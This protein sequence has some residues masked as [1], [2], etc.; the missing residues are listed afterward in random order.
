MTGRR[1]H[2]LVVVDRP[3]P[4]LFPEPFVRLVDE[5]HHVDLLGRD[6]EAVR[7]ELR[8]IEDVAD[9]AIEPLRLVFHR[10]ERRRTLGRIVDDA[11]EE[12]RNVTADRRQRCPKLVG[13]GHQ[14]V[15]LHL[16]DLGEPRHHLPET[17]AE[18]PQLTRRP[19]RDLD[20]IVAARDRVGSVGE[21]QNRPNDPMREIAARATQPRGGPGCRRA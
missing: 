8:E 11:L 20:F 12:R 16:L 1:L 2:L 5:L 21:L 4:R 14:E 19:L 3:P 7:V 17:F 18:V 6:R 15:P 13:H 10:L 9:E